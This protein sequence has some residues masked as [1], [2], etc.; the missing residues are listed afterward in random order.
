MFFGGRDLC[1]R[2]RAKKNFAEALAGEE[3]GL[4]AVEFYF[5]EFL[6]ALAF[7]FGLG[8]R[9]LAREFIDESEE[10]LGEFGEAGEG[11]GAV[12]GSGVGR[13]IGAEAA[14]IF[15]ELAAGALGGAGADD[16]GG[17]LREAGRAVTDG[18]VA[19]A[20][21]KFAVKFGNSVRF[22]EDDFES[23]LEAHLCALGPGNLALRRKRRDCGVNFGCCAGGHY[24][25]SLA[26]ALTGQR[27]TMA[28]LSLRRYFCATAWM[29]S[30]FT[31]RNPSR[32]VLTSC[33]SLSKSEKH[34]RRC[35]RP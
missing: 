2:V 11:D 5:F 8:K 20:E 9:G 28:R 15:F 34:A 29:S 27:K 18:G 3:A 10:R 6:A 22:R 25:A 23:V 1:V 16:G 35:I 31:A 17:H 19:G 21:E 14:E 12:V 24:A 4:G 7:E 32:I 13:E 33:G 30:R 26:C